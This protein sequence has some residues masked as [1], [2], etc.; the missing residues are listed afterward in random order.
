M[1]KSTLSASWQ[2]V[3]AHE[4]ESPKPAP[5]RARESLLCWSLGIA[6]NK[7]RDALC[8]N[9]IPVIATSDWWYVRLRGYSDSRRLDKGDKEELYRR[10]HPA[11]AEISDKADARFNLLE[12]HEKTIS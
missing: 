4:L 2:K 10:R 9:D 5:A 7:K 3:K 12:L 6:A 8:N 1:K 11:Q